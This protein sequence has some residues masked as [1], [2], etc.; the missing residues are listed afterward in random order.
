MK[1]VFI[2]SIF[3]NIIFGEDLVYKILKDIEN[4]KNIKNISKPTKII[5][6]Y[7]PFFPKTEQKKAKKKAKI[8]FTLKA[9]LNK[10]ALINGKWRKEG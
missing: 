4:I 1:I 5:I 9:I 3:F 6:N 2:L 10:E 8:H 7:D